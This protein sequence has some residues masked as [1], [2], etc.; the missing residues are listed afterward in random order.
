MPPTVLVTGAAGYVGRHLTRAL[1]A[2]GDYVRALVRPR[3]VGALPRH[4]RLDIFPGDVTDA[5]QVF[6]AVKGCDRVV[7]LAVLRNGWSADADAYERVNVGGTRNVLRAASAAGV[8]AVLHTSSYLVLGPASDG[9][10]RTEA[11]WGP[12][13]EFV[14]DLQRTKY[15][16]DREVDRFVA[17]GLPVVT[18]LPTTCYGGTEFPGKGAVIRMAGVVSRG[19]PVPIMGAGRRNLV[20]VDD[21]V[22]GLLATLDRGRAG[23]RY[24]LGGENATLRH[25]LDLLREL[26]GRPGR[27]IRMPV[28]AGWMVALLCE[29]LSAFTRREPLLT[30]SAVRTL[31]TDW[32]V[33]SHK[34]ERELGYRPTPLRPGLRLMFDTM[35]GFRR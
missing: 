1:L 26:C 21:V 27:A 5:D 25:L 4:D 10:P 35:P 2:R 11:D 14:G 6:H 33:S 7:H 24:I 9:V 12:L 23:E 32:A 13:T 22:E 15:L 8:A 30:R 18:A 16:A 20:H 31:C 28:A 29:T 3:S 34:A 19:W 17:S